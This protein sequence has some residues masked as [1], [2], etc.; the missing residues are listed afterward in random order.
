M[1]PYLAITSAIFGLITVAHIWRIAAENPRLATDPWF[2][3][4]TVVTAGL[5]LWGLRLLRS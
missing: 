2:V 4:L 5:C 3:I 1:K